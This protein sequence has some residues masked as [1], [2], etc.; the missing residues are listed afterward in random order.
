MQNPRYVCKYMHN[1]IISN[2]IA[3]LV[4]H[5][6][7][8]VWCGFWLCHLCHLFYSLLSPF[9]AQKLMTSSCFKR[10]AHLIEVLIVLACGLVPGTVVVNTA[11]Y[12]FSGFPGACYGIN[13]EVQ[14]YTLIL[15]MA[16]GATVGC[17]ILFLSFWILRKVRPV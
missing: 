11:G 14:F 4:V 6:G 2:F 13:S 15:P 1:R 7:S 8:L 16:L 3:G 5:S 10:Y 17:C 12:R 9:K